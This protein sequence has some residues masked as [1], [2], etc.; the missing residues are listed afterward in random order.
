MQDTSTIENTSNWEKH[1]NLMRSHKECKNINCAYTFCDGCEIE[2]ECEN[3]ECA[4]GYCVCNISDDES[5]DESDDDTDDETDNEIPATK[6]EPTPTPPNCNNDMMECCNSDGDV[7]G[8]CFT[9]IGNLEDMTLQE[10]VEVRK[11]PNLH[12]AVAYWLNNNHDVTTSADRIGLSLLEF[13][14]QKRDIVQYL[15]LLIRTPIELM[16]V[17][18]IIYDMEHDDEDDINTTI[19]SGI[20]CKKCNNELPPMTMK[21]H[22][23]GD[24]NK[25]C[26]HD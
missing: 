25:N 5:D 7:R 2:P 10:I 13:W 11:C 16:K 12:Y 4:D 26:P 21:Q 9:C 15:G 23:D 24:F 14:E 8:M 17:H 1:Y 22:L 19:V 3:P 18:D 6:I 20:I